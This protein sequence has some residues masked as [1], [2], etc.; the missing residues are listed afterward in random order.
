VQCLHR[1]QKVLN[2]DLVKG[3]WTK[4][5]RMGE[6]TRERERDGRHRDRKKREER[7]REREE[8]SVD[9]RSRGGSSL[10]Y[11]GKERREGE[12]E[13]RGLIVIVIDS[14][15]SL[16]IRLLSL[17][18][19]DHLSYVCVIESCP[20]LFEGREGRRSVWNEKRGR[21]G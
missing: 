18:V 8:V 7:E 20:C 3:P 21:D 11:K 5:V 6:S 16:R 1:W 19:C 17:Y 13:T 4:E 15:R 14:L 9:G 10:E 2:P 12:R